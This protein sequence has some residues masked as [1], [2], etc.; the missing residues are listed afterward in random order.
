MPALHTMI[1]L[2]FILPCPYLVEIKTDHF[3][4]QSLPSSAPGV[5]TREHYSQLEVCENS[6]MLEYP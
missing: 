2:S 6:H 4:H 3:L 1:Y 5:K